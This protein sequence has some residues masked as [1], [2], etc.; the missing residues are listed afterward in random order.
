MN[1]EAF[2]ED[3]RSAFSFWKT[4]LLSRLAT[5]DAVGGEA[6]M[7][8]VER[9]ELDEW[10]QHLQM[11][12]DSKRTRYAKALK[13]LLGDEGG[14]NYHACCYSDAEG[15]PRLNG[16]EMRSVVVALTDVERAAF[17]KYVRVLNECAYHAHCHV[18]PRVPETKEIQDNI[19]QRQTTDSARDS[20]IDGAFH[21]C[22]L[23]M[24]QHCGCSGDVRGLFVNMKDVSLQA[25]RQRWA[26]MAADAVD[27]RSFP[28]ACAA[29]VPAAWDR[30]RAEFGAQLSLRP[31]A[32]DEGVWKCAVQ[33]NGFAV[34]GSNVPSNMMG[35]IESVANQ[36]AGDIASGRTDMSNVSL[37]EIG[38]QVL[39][40]C[41]ESEMNHF[42]NNV[43]N[44]LP[45][46]NSLLRPA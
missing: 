3:A 32:P 45:S 40:G 18:P 20:S 6:H 24:L 29:H 8:P 44:I 26:A 33:L 28:D 22:F 42:A 41:D 11:P 14:V 25:L 30:I 16:I 13:R 46:L 39:A 37:E 4:Q 19:S 10:L 9:D 36:I 17:W 15:L 12:L 31:G 7:A 5:I 1:A 35:R 43:G 34:V 27:G 2:K 21:S 23:E 38:K